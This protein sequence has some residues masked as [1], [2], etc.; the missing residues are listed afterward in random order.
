MGRGALENRNSSGAEEEKLLEALFLKAENQ[1]PRIQLNID[2]TEYHVD[3]LLINHSTNELPRYISAH[4]GLQAWSPG[5]EPLGWDTYDG[6]GNNTSRTK[7]LC[8]GN[9]TQ[10]GLHFPSRCTAWPRRRG[11]RGVG[12][13]GHQRN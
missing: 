8:E 10:Q 5:I 2:V 6:A 9:E 12:R 3:N 1:V 7:N 4:R 11:S 13:Q